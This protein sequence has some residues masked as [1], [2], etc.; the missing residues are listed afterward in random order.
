VIDESKNPLL[1]ALL[2]AAFIAAIPS[3]ADAQLANATA[4]QVVGDSRSRAVLPVGRSGRYEE[5]RPLAQAPSQ[6]TMA[7]DTVWNGL[8]IGAGV[9]GLL[10]L[11]PDHYDDCEECH[12]SLY[13]SIAVGAGIGALIDLLRRNRPSPSSKDALHM[14]V[15]VRSRSLELA[16]R[17]AWR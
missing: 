15:T 5:E 16:G 1:G 13:A 14:G 7:R 12:D 10:G 6:P 4:R 11:I 3:R 9:G 17:I 2:L 8:L